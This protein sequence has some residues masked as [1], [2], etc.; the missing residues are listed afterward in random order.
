MSLYPFL[1]PN[2][3]GTPGREVQSI[4]LREH[5]LGFV[6]ENVHTIGLTTETLELDT[7]TR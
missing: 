1:A 2:P 3:Q 5:D 6:V 4:K 7:F